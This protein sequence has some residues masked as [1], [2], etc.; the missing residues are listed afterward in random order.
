MYKGFKTNKHASKSYVLVGCLIVTVRGLTE[1]AI[2]YSL[3]I[4]A[5]QDILVIYLT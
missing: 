4:V 1:Q 2:K 3:E 5:E